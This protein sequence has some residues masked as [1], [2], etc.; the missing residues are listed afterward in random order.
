MRRAV[1][2][3]DAV[4]PLGRGCS[5]RIPNSLGGT[6]A[7]P[8]GM[9]QPTLAGRKPPAR[10]GVAADVTSQNRVPLSVLDLSPVGSGQTTRDALLAST[11]LAQRAEELGY[12]RFWVAE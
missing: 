11:A 6:A 8:P 4:C 7:S 1:G 5:L 10:S 12:V 9:A 3:M 2:A